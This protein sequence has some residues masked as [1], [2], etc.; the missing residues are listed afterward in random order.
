MATLPTI[1]LILAALSL[2][3]TVIATLIAFRSQREASSAI[4]PIVREEEINR[5][6][7]ARVSIFV[8]VAITALFFG[9]WLG[10]LRL[11][12]PAPANPPTAAEVLPPT[13]FEPTEVAAVLES[14]PTDLPAEEAQVE[15]PAPTITAPA[16][17]DTVEP[18]PSNT[19]TPVPTDT[20]TAEPATNTPT[21]LPT[22]TP[23]SV[24]TTTPTNTAVPPTDTPLPP[25]A[26]PIPPTDTAE[27][28][29]S[30]VQATSTVSA[31]VVNTDAVAAAD[32]SSR[33]PAPD[34]IRVG[35]IEFATEITD[36]VQAIAPTDMFAEDVEKIF[37]VFPFSGME[38]GLNF[39]VLWYKDGAEFA[40]EEGQWVWGQN[41]RSFT[42]VRPQGE[43]LYKLELWVNDTVVATKLF[44][45]E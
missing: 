22:D 7:R 42:F 26:T 3:A 6:Q 29:A 2:G 17:E 36:D 15:Q 43:G 37:A 9:G 1:L 25:S 44:Q 13:D 8:W 24:P 12:S 21:P 28:N 18:T 20:P 11:A 38:Q 5:A 14:A 19:D 16:V 27:S 39:T 32:S 23:T 45:L 10:T 34:G 4:F 35:P 30:A 33:T 31:T 41:A 40:R